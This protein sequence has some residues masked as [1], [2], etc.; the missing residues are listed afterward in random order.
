MEGHRRRTP[1]APLP[2]P[3]TLSLM[4]HS[5]GEPHRGRSSA[6]LQWGRTVTSWGDGC[7]LHPRGGGG[8]H[9]KI[10][11]NRAAGGV[12]AG[13]RAGRGDRDSVTRVLPPTPI[14][15]PMGWEGGGLA[16]MP[17]KQPLATRNFPLRRPKYA[18]EAPS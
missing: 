11:W 7:K 9:D 12:G 18:A 8:V 6:S 1:L 2:P 3:R 5:L 17:M 15:M 14:P 13:C 16:G 10:G 4:A